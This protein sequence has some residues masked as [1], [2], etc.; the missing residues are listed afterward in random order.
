[1]LTA[2]DSLHLHGIEGIRIREVVDEISMQFLCWESQN[3][4]FRHFLRTMR[5]TSSTFS[6]TWPDP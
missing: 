4:I 3:R 6:A 5:A 1:V 2:C